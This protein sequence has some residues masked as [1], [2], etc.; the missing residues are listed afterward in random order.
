[1]GEE[2]RLARLPSVTLTAAAGANA[3]VCDLITNFGAGIFA[4][5][6]TGGAFEAQLDVANANQ[7]AAIAAYGL[8]CVD[9]IL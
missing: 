6:F 5:L 4:P 8:S 3:D 9:R 1:M 7:N 2:V